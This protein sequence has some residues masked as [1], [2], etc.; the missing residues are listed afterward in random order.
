MYYFFFRIINLHMF[1]A[2]FFLFLLLPA[3]GIAHDCWFVTHF[4]WTAIKLHWGSFL[5]CTIIKINKKRVPLCLHALTGHFSDIH[6][7]SM[8]LVSHQF[9]SWTLCCI[10]NFVSV[11][12]SIIISQP[13]VLEIDWVPCIQCY[14]RV[15]YLN[16]QKPFPLWAVINKHIIEPFN[17]WPRWDSPVS[18]MLIKHTENVSVA[19]IRL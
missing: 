15:S 8:H 9:S 19:H 1:S 4:C 3:T 14:L 17:Y 5:P 18:I 2:D 13:F 10:E 6:I 7:I 11:S 12:K 16:I